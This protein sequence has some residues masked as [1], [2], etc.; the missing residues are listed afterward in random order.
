MNVIARDQKLTHSTVAT[1]LKDKERIR[2]D[3][4]G[5]TPM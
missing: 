1:I 2:N 5:C 4:K 3:V